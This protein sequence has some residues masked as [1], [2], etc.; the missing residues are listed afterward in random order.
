M[1]R[2]FT[3]HRK[4][5]SHPEHPRRRAAFLLRERR[6][7][8]R[9]QGPFQLERDD[10]GDLGPDRTTA[11][12]NKIVV[13]WSKTAVVGARLDVHAQDTVLAFKCVEVK[14]PIQAPDIAPFLQPVY[15]RIFTKHG[16]ATNL[17]NWYCRFIAGTRIVSRHGY[18]D[19]D[20]WHGAAQDFGADNGDELEVMAFEI[21]S[22]ATDPTDKDMF[23][24]VATI[25]VHD[26]IWE[27]GDAA[28]PVSRWRSYSG[29]YHYHVHVDVDQGVPCSP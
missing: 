29:I 4:G 15:V 24:R 2:Q 3:V 28:A 25:I 9:A 7:V 11:E 8:A 18:Y 12:V 17:G 16:Y 5:A 26:R 19:D 20:T 13:Q 10:D 27:R 14:P 21:M 23:G 1:S 22:W 6:L